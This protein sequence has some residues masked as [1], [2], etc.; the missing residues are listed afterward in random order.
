MWAE[1][2]GGL[3][4]RSGRGHGGM[5]E[6]CVVRGGR[7]YQK[8]CEKLEIMLKFFKTTIVLVHKKIIALSFFALCADV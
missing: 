6:Y 2:R 7:G 4:R 3:V 1:V 5:M 8:F